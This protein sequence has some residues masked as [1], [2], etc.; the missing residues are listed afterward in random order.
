[1]LSPYKIAVI[2]GKSQVPML[3]AIGGSEAL[4]LNTGVPDDF[5]RKMFGNFSGSIGHFN[6]P[7]SVSEQVTR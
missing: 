5:S 3:G 6:G 1:M 7:D 4:K 2:F